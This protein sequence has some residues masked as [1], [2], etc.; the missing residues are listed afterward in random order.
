VF[1]FR[2][3]RVSNTLSLDGDR[4]VVII[5]GGEIALD[6]EIDAAICGAE[7]RDA[8]PGGFDGGNRRTTALGEGGGSGT[9][10][11][12]QGGGGGGHGATGGL[13][14]AGG[15]GGPAF[16]IANLGGGG[17]GGGGGGAG[18]SGFG[19]GGGASIQLV[20]NTVITVAAA[21]GI[22]AGGCGGDAGTGANDAG[23]GGGAG[24]TILLEAPSITIAGALAVN[25]GSGGTHNAS[26]APATRDRMP[27]PGAIAPVVADGNGGAG[28]AANILAGGDASGGTFG[29]GGG[30][31]GRMRFQ[32]RTGTATVDNLFLS[33]ALDDDPTST[34]QGPASI[35]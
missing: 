34:T 27:A 25:G 11:N 26:G 17:G 33:P 19:A 1:R 29:A 30:A 3:L 21:G 6:A 9:L 14:G 32:T 12:A 8:G 15:L 18:N 5:A 28:G 2:S 4:A 10:T 31:V 23:G 20:S 13:G 16:D 35:E 7:G 24:G 22:N